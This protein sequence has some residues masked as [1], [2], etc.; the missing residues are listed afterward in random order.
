[1]PFEIILVQHRY[2]GDTKIESV[3][4]I[5]ESDFPEIV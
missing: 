2:L 3:K 1:M 5:L 4:V